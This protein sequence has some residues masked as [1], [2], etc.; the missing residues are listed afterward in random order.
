MAKEVFIRNKKHKNI[1][2]DEEKFIR[3]T[4]QLK[5]LEYGEF[6]K[7]SNEKI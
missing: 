2:I 3:K 6:F 7:L 1:H 5:I 4:G